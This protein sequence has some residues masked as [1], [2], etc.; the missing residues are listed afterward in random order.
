MPNDQLETS[1]IVQARWNEGLNT[2]IAM[3][4]K[5]RGYKYKVISTKWNRKDLTIDWLLSGW[6]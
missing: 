1:T 6:G 2:S 3:R 4:M 5:G